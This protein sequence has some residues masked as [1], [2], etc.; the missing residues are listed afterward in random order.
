MGMVEAASPLRTLVTQ[1]SDVG[2]DLVS[3]QPQEAVFKLHLFFTCSV[4]LE[5]D[6][7]LQIFQ[8]AVE[9]RLEQGIDSS[10]QER[11]CAQEEISENIFSCL[12]VIRQDTAVFCQTTGRL[13]FPSGR[14]AQMPC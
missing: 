2:V 9:P 8:V 10:L 4:C 14:P 7:C 3:H 1:G 5:N 11:K 6:L 12:T 13:G